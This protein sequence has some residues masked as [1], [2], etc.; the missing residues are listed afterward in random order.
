MNNIQGM[1]Q[2]FQQFQRTFQGDPRQQIQQLMNSGRVTQA[3]YDAA[4]KQAQQ[5]M[6]MFGA[7]QVPG[8]FHTNP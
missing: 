4:V 8:Y 5:L 2:R 1:I 6:Q 7:D 3:Q